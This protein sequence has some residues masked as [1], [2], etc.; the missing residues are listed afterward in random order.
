[1][2]IFPPN[3]SPHFEDDKQISTKNI[4]VF[5]SEILIRITV[6]LIKKSCYSQEKWFVAGVCLILKVMEYADDQ[7]PDNSL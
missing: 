1:M 4:D 7:S 3:Y 6:G 2:P 5:F